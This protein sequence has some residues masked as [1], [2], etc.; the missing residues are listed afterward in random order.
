MVNVSETSSALPK[1]VEEHLKEE[2]DPAVWE[3]V[4]KTVAEDASVLQVAGNRSHLYAEVG[5]CSHWLRPHQTRWTAAGGFALPIGY[6]DGE[7]F[8]RFGLPGFAWRVK[9]QFNPAFVA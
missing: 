2:D 3:L 7:G 9:L 6:G 4:L 1:L 8:A 5:A